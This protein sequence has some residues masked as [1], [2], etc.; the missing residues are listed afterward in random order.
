MKSTEAQLLN[1][2]LSSQPEPGTGGI[3]DAQKRDLQDDAELRQRMKDMDNVTA[4]EFPSL[5]KEHRERFAEFNFG[6]A[7]AIADAPPNVVSEVSSSALVK[8]VEAGVPWAVSFAEANVIDRVRP[9]YARALKAGVDPI[10]FLQ[11]DLQVSAEEAQGMVDALQAEEAKKD[12][13]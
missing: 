4:R 3:T 11:A 8:L 12:S 10:P 1:I 13:K 7:L 6:L 9:S 2:L 5:P